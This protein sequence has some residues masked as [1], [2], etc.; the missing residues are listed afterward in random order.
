M[1]DDHEDGV[2]GASQGIQYQAK[3]GSETSP[4]MIKSAFTKLV[5]GII[6]QNNLPENCH[7]IDWGTFTLESVQATTMEGEEIIFLYA[8]VDALDVTQ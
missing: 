7:I 6:E 1:E 8:E 3:I 5:D 2:T 4:E